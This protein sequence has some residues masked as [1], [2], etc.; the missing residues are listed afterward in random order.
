MV[1]A[2]HPGWVYV[3]QGIDGGPFKVGYTR[4]LDKRL[5]ALQSSS[6]VRL[7]VVKK[8]EGCKQTEQRLHALL[9]SYRLHGE[10]FDA[11]SATASILRFAIG[12][13]VPIKTGAPNLAQLV[14]KLARAVDGVATVPTGSVAGIVGLSAAA[15]CD[16]LEREGVRPAT[17]EVL[18]GGSASRDAAIVAALVPVDGRATVPVK[19]AAEMLGIGRNAVR[20]AARR[21]GVA[22]L[23]QADALRAH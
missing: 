21:A 2:T 14:I 12:R 7:H 20:S 15:V 16:I 11:T 1:E 13:A 23:S 17:R 19:R 5:R 22:L 4:D 10:W 18:R 9:E 6:P 3:V 8:I